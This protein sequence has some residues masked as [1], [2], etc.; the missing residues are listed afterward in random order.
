MAMNWNAEFGGLP[1]INLP[2]RR[3]LKTLAS[4]RE[5]I[6]ELPGREQ[7]AIHWQH[8]TQA[9]LKAAEHGGPFCFIARI[10]VSRALRGAVRVDPAPE[11]RQN[12]PDRWKARR[13]QRP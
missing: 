1:P 2:G 11:P 3:K 8:A 7:E 10:A 13:K 6:L 9:L 5:Y 4:C 12:K